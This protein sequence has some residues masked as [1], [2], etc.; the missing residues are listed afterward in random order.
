MNKIDELAS[1]HHSFILVV[2]WSKTKVM[3]KGDAYFV[4]LETT[5][6]FLKIIDYVVLG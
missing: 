3:N 6:I 4:P 5:A 1:L 2:T